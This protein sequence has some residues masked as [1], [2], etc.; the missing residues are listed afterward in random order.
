[1]KKKHTEPPDLQTLKDAEPYAR[2]QLLR[3]WICDDRRRNQLFEM[4]NRDED[5]EY[6]F[7]SRDAGP[8]EGDNLGYEKPRPAPVFGH[9]DVTLVTKRAQIE[10]MLLNEEHKYSSR[11]YAE[12]GGGNF[13]LAL[14][15][16]DPDVHEMQR[17][18][19]RKCFP[20]REDA[21]RIGDLA[22]L[23]CEAAAI[24]SL[25]A[26]EF[27]LA[28]LAEQAALRFCQKL[29]GYALTDFP[30]LQQAI[31]AGYAGLVYQVLGRHFVTDPTAIPAARMGMA[32]LVK[33]TSTLIDAYHERDE[34]ALR[35]TKDTAVPGGFTPVMAKLARNV[36]GGMNSEQR[37]ILIAGSA[38]GTVGNVQAAVCIA[39]KSFFEHPGTFDEMYS[40]AR[41]DR[42]PHS[43]SHLGEWKGCI[44]G[45]LR[46]N[47]PIP[48]LPRIA[49]DSNGDM[50]REYLLALGG[51][52]SGRGE[53]AGDDPLVWGLP[54]GAP[55]W[56]LGKE[57]AWPL[58]VE[59]VRLVMGLP[60]LD[61]LLDPEDATA[62]GL[63]KRWGF[64]CESYPLTHQRERRI[65]QSSLNVAMRLKPP[66][67]DNA[68][69]A[70]TIIAA[71]A[72]RIEAA[73]REARHVHF[74]WFEL[75]EGD[76]VLVLHTVY[77]GPFAPYIQHFALKC[78][79]MFDALFQCIE[80]P[81]PMPVDKFPDEFV[82]HILRYNRLPAMGY[83]FSAYPNSEVTRILRDADSRPGRP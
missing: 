17:D 38:L 73:L 63:T 74:A 51:A 24:L 12:L 76:T 3:E 70:R 31:R 9:K 15:R 22:Y 81:P 69:L 28:Q 10:K 14:D 25:R 83:F 77:D 68:D 67:K 78:G 4:L 54:D 61:Q 79:D 58:I 64:A 5:G 34:D 46:E 52:T 29:M 82:A 62:F 53:G 36:G 2:N 39:V 42:L 75:T 27:D 47:P 43:T 1:M 37:A 65:A 16:E 72:P 49:V 66:V 6:P 32:Q 71:G 19:Y 50:V 59:I 13:M 26:P 41:R 33:R 57:L 40:L 30:L 18:A 48:F 56:C 80:N 8:R 45:A 7:P 44:Q 60:A 21:Q 23:A 55:H 11:V 35:G 20:G